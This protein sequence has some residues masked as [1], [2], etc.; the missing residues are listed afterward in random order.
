[1]LAHRFTRHERVLAALPK[2]DDDVATAVIRRMEIL[3]GRL[4]MLLKAVGGSDLQRAQR[5]L[6]ETVANLAAIPNP[7][8]LDAAGAARFDRLRANKRLKKIGRADV[9][10]AAITLANRA[11]LGTRDRED[12]SP[13]LG[14]QLESRADGP[15]AR[16]C[17]GRQGVSPPG[18]AAASAAGPEGL[19]T[20]FC[21][22]EHA[23]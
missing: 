14:L 1:M 5:W 15:R 22:D 23:R 12:F 10:I 17:P 6:D 21:V 18:R 7:L 4:A 8:W 2:Q 9:L 16:C 20:E 11:T 19:F 13:V 3:P